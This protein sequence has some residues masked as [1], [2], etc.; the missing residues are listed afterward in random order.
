MATHGSFERFTERARK[1]LTLAQEE[2]ERFNHSY[3]GTEHLLLGLIREA[4]GVAAVVLSNLG[5]E[6]Q[7]VRS[8]VELIIG[9]G[10][11]Q[12]S[13]EIGLMPRAKK[14]IELAV[15]EAHHLGH[16][17]IG[18]EHLLLGLVREGDGIAAGVLESFGVN[19]G[20]VRIEVIRVLGQ[21]EAESVSAETTLPSQPEI[22]LRSPLPKFKPPPGVS[23]IGGES[24]STS[25]GNGRTYQQ[26]MIMACE[27]D[28]GSHYESEFR[29][30]D[31]IL[32]RRDESADGRGLTSVWR[33]ADD[34]GDTWRAAL[35]VTEI[36]GDP[37]RFL[38]YVLGW[39]EPRNWR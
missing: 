23:D 6:I 2:A 33:F 9:R 16:H 21:S 22:N 18:T 13:G 17:Y 11:R 12:I 8:S 25:E 36:Y 27:Q 30:A 24:S 15:D 32:F 26:Y 3:I 35:M 7:K 37:R 10:E 20:K 38:V 1:V 31:W 19:L 14:V 28:P 4:D 29:E 34:E 39:W 5:V